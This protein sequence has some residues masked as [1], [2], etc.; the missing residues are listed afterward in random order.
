MLTCCISEFESLEAITGV[1]VK[2]YDN[3]G[4][5]DSETV[6]RALATIGTCNHLRKDTLH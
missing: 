1:T 2:L 4:P 5:G 6:G 3:M